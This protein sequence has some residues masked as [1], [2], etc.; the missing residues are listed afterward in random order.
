MAALIAILCLASICLAQQTPPIEPKITETPMPPAV[1]LPAPP[2]IPDDVPNRPLTADE[3]VQIALRHQSDIAV[4]HAGVDAAR[5][6]L[7]ETQAGQLPSLTVGVGHTSLDTN[8]TSNGGGLSGGGSSTG[9]RGYQL[10]A[11][12]RQL[13]FDFGHTRELVRQASAQQR[14]ATANLTRAQS[15]LAFQVK[16]S[17]YTYVQN[18][19]LVEVEGSNIKGRQGH[20][21]LAK[22]RLEAGVGLPS[23]VVRAETARANAIFALNL[24]QAST[25]V[26]RVVLAELM[27][28]DPRTPIQAAD[29][30][31]RAVDAQDVDALVERAFRAPSGSPAGG[32]DERSRRTW[33]RC[34]E[35]RQLTK[36]RRQ[37]RMAPARVDSIA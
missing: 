35:D 24:A 18:A 36:P 4:A 16:Q 33:V 17:F 26:S 28:I 27:G 29:S 5:G 13:L 1:E 11:T 25:S 3:A 8:G 6:R 15:D 22:A 19:R 34:R 31:E 32:G 30:E 7:Q 10:S 20:L 21:D 9:S 14:S 12:A 23:D 37:R 2:G